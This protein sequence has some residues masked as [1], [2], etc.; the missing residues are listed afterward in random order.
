MVRMV[1]KMAVH[2]NHAAGTGNRAAHMLELHGRVV[3]VEAVA[4]DVIHLMQ[5]VIAA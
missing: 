3:D 2:G 1:I 4:K 5:D